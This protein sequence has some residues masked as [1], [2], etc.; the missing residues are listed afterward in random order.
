MSP[1]S[2]KSKWNKWKSSEK[3]SSCKP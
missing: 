2:W 1:M 3:L